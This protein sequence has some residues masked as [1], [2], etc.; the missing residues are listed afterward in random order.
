VHGYRADALEQLG[1]GD[2][3]RLQLNPNLI[4]VALNAYGWNGPWHMRRGFDT[5]VQMSAGLAA[6]EMDF[7]GK[8]E[9]QQL[10]VQVLDYGT[11]HLMAAAVLRALVE[12]QQGR[13]SKIRFSLARTAQE[14]LL[15]RNLDPNR[16]VPETP[17]DLASEVEKS[18][19]GDAK[20]LKAPVHIG[21]HT[22]VFERP[23]GPLGRDRPCFS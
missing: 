6:A 14:V 7:L 15:F 10:P 9:P 4:D 3:H 2:E 19:W 22:F 20:R 1:F 8:N 11:G 5:I 23:A 12:A 21:A 18:F 17:E 13:I 16:L